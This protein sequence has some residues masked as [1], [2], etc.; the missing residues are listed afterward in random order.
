MSKTEKLRLRLLSSPSDFTWQELTRLLN[1]FGFAEFKN[2]KT[3][4]SGRKF[5][6]AKKNVIRLHRP[7]PGNIVKEYALKQVIKQLKDTGHIKDE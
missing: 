2:G 4:G 3:G 7:H 5:V 1:L 6:D